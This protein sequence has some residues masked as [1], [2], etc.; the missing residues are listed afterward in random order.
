MKDKGLTIIAVALDSAGEDA[1]R[2]WI[3]AANPTYPCLIDRTHQVAHDYGILNVPTGVWIDEEGRI[4]RPAESL[5]S[6][7]TNPY[8]DTVTGQVPP[9]IQDEVARRRDYYYSALRD[10]VDNGKDSQFVM[11]KEEL[12]RRMK[13]PTPEKEQATAYFRLGIHLQQE[14]NPEEADRL[15][16]R[17][18]LVWPESWTFLRQSWYWHPLPDWGTL[19]GPPRIAEARKTHPMVAPLDM[20]GIGDLP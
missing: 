11:S 10:W 9:E 7:D 2:P 16:E 14:G 18:A 20:P 3:E 6:F 12:H 4:V 19:S 17:A 13:L 1:A 15:F 8:R 5:G